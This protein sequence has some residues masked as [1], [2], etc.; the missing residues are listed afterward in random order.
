MKYSLLLLIALSFALQS[1]RDR[2][3][4][5]FQMQIEE[6]IN[7]N[8]GLNSIETHVF[9]LEDIPSTLKALAQQ[10]GI[11][12][13]E[14]ASVKPAT[15]S[16]EGVFQEHDYS[17]VEEV[18]IDLIDPDDSSNNREVFYQELINLNHKGPLQLF[19]T[20]PDLKEILLKDTYNLEI[21]IRFRTPTVQT[22]ENRLLFN[23]VAYGN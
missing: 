7:F 8:A 14:I 23:F 6:R 5:L 19:G 17:I 9:L 18:T 11:S 4:E 15:A 16:F 12:I 1:C 20:L 13:E 2:T 3:P 10:K 22:F 21:A